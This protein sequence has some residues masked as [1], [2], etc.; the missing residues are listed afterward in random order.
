MRG[1]PDSGGEAAAECSEQQQ[2]QQEQQHD[3]EE[4]QQQ[5]GLKPG[6]RGEGGGPGGRRTQHRVVRLGFR[7]LGFRV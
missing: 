6:S 4:Q 3:D 7:V 1:P 2:Q 5:Q